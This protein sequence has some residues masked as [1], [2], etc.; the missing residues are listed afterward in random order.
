MAY[1]WAVGN[2][3]GEPVGYIAEEPRGF[4]GVIARQAFAT[5]RPF[6]AVIMDLE[7]SP[8]MWASIN[9]KILG[10]TFNELTNSQWQI[11]RP[12]AWINSRMYVQRLKDFS[13]YTLGG[14]PVLDTFAE[15]QQVWHPWRRRYNLFIR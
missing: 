6:R 11:R 5:H 15:V 9:I 1:L 13:E 4:F 2:E 8:V 14:E 10:F 7:G 3:A 12:F